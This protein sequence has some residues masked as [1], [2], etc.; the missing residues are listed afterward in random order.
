MVAE[1]I[2][3]F[4]NEGKCSFWAF[5]IQNFACGACNGYVTVRNQSVFV[6]CL[7]GPE[8]SDPGGG[9]VLNE[10]SKTLRP[11]GKPD[12][13]VHFIGHRRHTQS[14]AAKYRSETGLREKRPVSRVC[15]RGRGYTAHAPRTDSLLL[16]RRESRRHRDPQ[17]H[18]AWELQ[19]LRR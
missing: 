16:G 18:H 19:R 5:G 8:P 1:A 12:Q 7:G 15:A 6:S 17:K 2:L 9:S 14:A 10:R 4:K 11:A 13:S 3:T